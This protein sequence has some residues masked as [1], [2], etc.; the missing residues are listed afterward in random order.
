MLIHFR[1]EVFDAD[2]LGKDKSLGI[3]EI[4]PSDLNSNEPKWYPLE[5]LLKVVNCIFYL[6]YK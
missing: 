5:V 4:N 6:N 2:K 1:V 3:V